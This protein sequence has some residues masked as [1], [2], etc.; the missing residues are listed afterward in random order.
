M[1]DARGARRALFGSL[2]F[3]SGAAALVYELIW[4]RQL[5][6]FFGST[7]HSVTTVVAAYMGGLGLGA[8]VLGRRADR[9]ANP[10]RLYGVLE[11]A[12]G[13]FGIAS[14]F[15][16]YEVGRGYLAVARTLEPGLWA[17]TAIKFVFA[18]AVLL[19][20]TFLMGGTLPILTRAFAGE[21]TD[22]LRR[23]LALFYGL[24][25]VGG[26]AGCMLAGYALIEYVGLRQSLIATGFLN[27]ALGA[28]ALALA[29]RRA[30]ETPE[31]AAG[32]APALG[33]DPGADTRRLALWL[34]AIT[35]FASLLYEIAWT[36]VLVL[37]VGSSTYA[38]TTILAC[39]LFGIGFGS[40]VAIGRGW[41]SRDLLIRSALIQ[42][43]IGVLAS[44]LFP[45]FGALPVYIVGTLQVS[46]LTPAELLVLQG[47]A[48]AVVVVPP[49]FG[50]GLSFPILA[51]LAA[52]RAGT[53]GRASGRA[54]FANTLGS[55]AGAVITGFLLIHLIG[56]ERTLQL[57]VVVNVSAAAVMAWWLYRERAAGGLPVPVERLPLAIGALALVVT[58]AT[59]SWSRR[60]LDR[61][62]AIYGKEEMGRWELGNF[63]RGYGAEQLVFDEGWNAAISVWRNG[64][65]T[66]LKSN[67]KA[68]ASSVA[69]MNTQ[70][71]VGLMPALAHPAPR[72]AFVLGFGSGA[73][74]RT[75]ADVPGLERID[76]VEIERAVLRAAPHFAIVNRDVLHDPRVRVIEDDARSALQLAREPYDIVVAEPTN[77]W[78][79]GVA[80][81][82][83]RDF[84]RVVSAHLADDGVF[85]QWVQ[86]YRVPQGVI[87]VVV[88]NLRSV[89]P[90][91]ELWY[92]NPNDLILL[93]S[94]RPIRWSQARVAAL[95]AP[96]TPLA[97]SF[98]DWLEIDRPSQLLGRFL[99][100]ER[101]TATLAGMALFQHSDNRPSLEFV[102]AR[103][104]LGSSSVAATF[105]SL[106]GI[107]AAAGDTLP[108]L[109]DWPLAPG[110]WQAAYGRALP[111]TSRLALPY[112]EEALRLAPADA[113][114]RGEL[115]RVLVDRD[116]FRSALSYLLPAL[117]KRPNDPRLL[118]VAGVAAAAGR[119]LA[120]ARVYL[121]RAR[122]SGGDSVYATSVLAEMLAGEGDYE[123]AATEALRAL[124]GLRPTIATPFPSA[125]ESTVRKLALQAPPAVAAPVLD[126]AAQ[127]RP[128]WDLAFHGGARVYARWG[129]DHCGQA[130]RL[131][132][133]LPRFGWTETEAN[134]LL[135]PCA[136][137]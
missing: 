51:E 8:Y 40:L 79:A 94:R 16:L 17:A 39:F 30:L 112:A 129:G 64:N 122:A 69:D 83:T 21:R 115:G 23:E 35:A 5:Y 33:P 137:R 11:L 62:P 133:Q 117:E 110:E 131:V 29:G 80:A 7:I 18:F 28:A 114:R 71:M 44:L 20:P 116:Q 77:P 101:G 32:R 48:V 113:E 13:A 19:V 9:D 15:V 132:E 87:S 124:R 53:T 109:A 102:A 135:R 4:V 91:V 76:V 60:L 81:L 26:V 82:F 1:P 12:I 73:S 127:T 84:F 46:F 97:Q 134:G 36:R 27:L 41:P 6:Q 56:S 96:G 63:L 98:H 85:S 106:L 88:A 74:A 47:L 118:V 57:G 103:G 58:F 130:A 31:P 42:G 123:R 121:E 49:A 25:T 93:A 67:G 100:G 128:S 92:A 52:E 104:L 55:I 37:V 107:R 24:N 70:V 120:G 90:H 75:V 125:L 14:P 86:T 61:G 22:H 95:M 78:I 2:F 38:F 108:Q 105:D 50:M 111:A 89:F 59:P 99:L 119:D 136:R 3:L 34:I 126:A 66:W 68:D 72:R 65:A 54:Y 45:F 10:A 43:A